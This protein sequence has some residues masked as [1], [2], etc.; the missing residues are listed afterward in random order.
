MLMAETRRR[1]RS[2]FDLIGDYVE[3]LETLSEE[4][5]GAAMAERPSWDLRSCCIEPL[6]NVFVAADEVVV[7]A[8]LPN[9]DPAKIKVEQINKDAL[10]IKAEMK[11]KI[12][13]DEFGITYRQGEFQFFRCQTHIPVSVDIKRMKTKFKRGILEVHLPRKRGYRIKGE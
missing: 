1:R 2:I 5:S 10:E 3:E 12:R 4:L 7:T 9:T 8:D 6:C 11:R 13:F